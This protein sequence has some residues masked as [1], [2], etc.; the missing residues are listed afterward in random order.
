MAENRSRFIKTVPFGGYDRTDVDK[1]LEFLYAQVYE[2]KNELRESKLTLE[3]LRKG[4]DT[5][6]T[7]ESVLAVERAK[8]TEMQVKNETMSERLKRTEDDNKSKDKT[9]ADLTERNEALNAALENATSELNALRAGGDA[10]ALGAVFVEAQKSKDMLMEAAKKEADALKSDSEALA[11]GIIT[12]ADN[13]AATIIYEAEKRAAEIDAEALTRSEQMKVASQNLKASMLQEVKGIHEQVALLR[14]AMEVFEKD[15]FRMV[16]DSEKLL[17]DTM[18]ELK[19]GGVP[20]FTEAKRVQPQLPDAPELKQVSFPNGESN[21]EETRK[22]NSELDKLQAMAEAIGGE[23]KGGSEKKSSGTSLEELAKQA[24][25]LDGGKKE[26]PSGGGISLA[27]LARQAQ[28]I[29]GGEPAPKEDSKSSKGAPNLADLA[30]QAQ[31]LGGEKPKSSGKPMAPPQAS[32]N[33]AEL[34]RQAEEAAKK[35]KR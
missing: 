25:A 4:T 15:G 23:K 30:K 1:R 3:K 10:A 24:A 8:L 11:E 35:N 9:I 27:D 26:A 19:K 18:D 34:T 13:K 22:K 29:G 5:E 31:S 21:S 12:D 16:T 2:L 28:S 14:Q 33:L 17:T 32:I 7:H 6:K 20:V